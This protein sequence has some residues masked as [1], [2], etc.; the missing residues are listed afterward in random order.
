MAH[1]PVDPR[2]VGPVGFHRHH[3]ESVV[4]DQFLGDPGPH[5]IE[6]GRAM[7]GLAEQDHPGAADPLEERGQVGALDVREWMGALPDQGGE[8]VGVRVGHPLAPQAECG[9]ATRCWRFI[10]RTRCLPKK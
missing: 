5:V 7:G 2:G 3:A 6:L 10:S 1:E 8:Q 4:P 9:S